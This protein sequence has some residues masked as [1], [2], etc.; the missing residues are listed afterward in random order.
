MD[1]AAAP[2]P[3][4]LE[5][6]LDPPVVVNKVE[7]ARIALRE[8]TLNQVQTAQA[9]LDDPSYSSPGA[10]RDYAL[11]FVAVVSR[12]PRAVVDEMPVRALDQ[13]LDYLQAFVTAD[14]PA[15]P[16][17]MPDQYVVELDPPI[18]ANGGEVTKLDLR[19]PRG[20]ELNRAEALLGRGAM[21]LPGAV[22]RYQARLIQEV[23][24]VNALAVGQ[25]PIRKSREAMRYLEGFVNSAPATGKTSP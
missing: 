20:G 11:T 2:L 24:G 17:G 21:P 6:A 1:E 7:Y 18:V 3:D 12:L 22:R 23:S 4:T 19:E 8:P 9:K 14:L 13:A 5:I 15:A 10:M 25:L 16:E